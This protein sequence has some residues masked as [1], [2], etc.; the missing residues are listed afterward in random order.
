MLSKTVYNMETP[1]S[2][3]D[4]DLQR[5]SFLA[6]NRKVSHFISAYG[7]TIRSMYTLNLNLRKYQH[8]KSFDILQDLVSSLEWCHVQSL[9]I[10]LKA[11][12]A[13]KFGKHTSHFVVKHSIYKHNDEGLGPINVLD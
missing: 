8:F 13:L 11:F 6:N 7:I 4:L 10:Y 5:R 2:G 12:S 1:D 3:C 9:K